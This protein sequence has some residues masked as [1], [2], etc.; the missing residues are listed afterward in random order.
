MLT[1]LGWEQSLAVCKG[2]G[3]LLL[4]HP[5]PQESWWICVRVSVRTCMPAQS[6]S[7]S[8]PTLWTPWTVAHQTPLSMGFSRQEYLVV[9]PT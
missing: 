2:Q 9:F 4:Q 6:I 1:D 7:K 8:C 5:E 3:L